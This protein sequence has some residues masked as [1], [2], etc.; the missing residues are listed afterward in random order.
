MLFRKRSK[1]RTGDIR[2]LD[3]EIIF[4]NKEVQIPEKSPKECFDHLKALGQRYL[5]QRLEKRESLRNED[6]IDYLLNELLS[7]EWKLTKNSF[8]AQPSLETGEK[9]KFL[10]QLWH[11]TPFLKTTNEEDGFD[12]KSC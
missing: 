4:F 11:S 10:Q 1:F 8:D 6:L 3:R 5:T 12:A 9:I 7:D 2:K